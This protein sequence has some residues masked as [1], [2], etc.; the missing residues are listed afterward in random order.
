MKRYRGTMFRELTEDDIG[1]WMGKIH[2]A[3]SHFGR[4]MPNDVGKQLIVWDRQGYM[5]T[6]KQRVE[7][8]NCQ[9]KTETTKASAAPKT[10]N[11]VRILTS[12]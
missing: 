8:K 1:K 5:E 6:E 9:R 11:M 10:A 12:Q 3:F 2:F 4:V 7:R